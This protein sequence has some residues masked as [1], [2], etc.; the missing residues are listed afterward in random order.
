VKWLFLLCVAFVIRAT[1]LKNSFDE[2]T[3]PRRCYARPGNIVV[4]VIEQLAWGADSVNGFAGS[5][6]EAPNNP[7]NR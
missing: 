5:F 7:Q 3:G 1:T 2:S 4:R 6:G